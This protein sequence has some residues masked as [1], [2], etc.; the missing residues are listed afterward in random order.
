MASFLGMSQLLADEKALQLFGHILK[1]A[2]LL[3]ELQGIKHKVIW[4]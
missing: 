4:C 1:Y 2:A 3:R